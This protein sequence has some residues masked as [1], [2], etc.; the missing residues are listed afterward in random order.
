MNLECMYAMHPLVSVRASAGA[1][2]YIHMRVR[3]L[4]TWRVLVRLLLIQTFRCLAVLSSLKGLVFDEAQ[5]I[6]FLYSIQL[7]VDLICQSY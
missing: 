5:A 3:V 6:H 4:I 1:V 2:L 7:G